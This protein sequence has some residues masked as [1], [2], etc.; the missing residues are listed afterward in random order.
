MNNAL[1]EKNHLQNP[2]LS[3]GHHISNELN[4]ASSVTKCT[5]TRLT[6]HHFKNLCFSTNW[7]GLF[8]NWLCFAKEPDTCN[9]DEKIPIN[10]A[11]LDTDGH[12]NNF[13]SSFS[14]YYNCGHSFL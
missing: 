13:T 4:K 9:G 5:Y 7:R 6:C 2:D 1:E 8:P 14:D 10:A 3:N 11:Y 12:S